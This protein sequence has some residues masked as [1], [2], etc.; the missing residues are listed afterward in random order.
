MHYL[1]TLNSAQRRAVEH[2][3]GPL[4]ILAGAGAG[5]TKTLTHRIFHLIKKGVRPSEILAITF[6]NKAAKEMRDRVLSLIS[7]DS[8]WDGEVPFVSTFHALGVYIL[9]NEHTHHTRTKYFSIMDQKDSLAV[10]KEATK[11]LGLD[12]KIHEPKKT[13]AIISSQ[14][15]KC[16]TVEMFARDAQSHLGN[17]VASIWTRY[18]EKIK[19]ENAY[20]FDDLLMQ[21]VFLFEQNKEVLDK[22]TNLWKY[23][24]IDEYQDTNETQYRIT[25]ALARHRN[26]CVVGDGDQ[27]IYTWRG[28]DVT[29]ILNFEQ[30]YPDVLVVVLEEN[31]RSTQKIL[32]A[33][34]AVISKNIRRKEKNLFTKNKEGENITIYEAS[35][36]RREAEYVQQTI[37]G[38][39]RHGVDTSH[40]AILYRANF[41]SRILEEMMLSGNIPYVVLGVRFFDRAEVKDILSYARSALNKDS[42]TD[43]K[44]II[45]TPK[46]G[47]GKVTI[48]KLFAGDKA[49]LPV[50]TLKKINDFYTLLDRIRIFSESHLPSETIRFILEESGI[51]KELEQSGTE[52]D[53][54]RVENMEELI[55]FALKYDYFGADGILK[56]IEDAALASDQDSL[57]DRGVKKKQE[58]V[59]LMTVHASKGLEFPHV[60]IV[61]LEQDLFPH[62]FEGKDTGDSD[63]EEERRLFYVAL[64]RAEQQVYLCY[65]L[66]RYIHG[67][68]HMQE[69]SE[70]LKDIPEDLVDRDFDILGS[71]SSYSDDSNGDEGGVME[72]LVID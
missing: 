47:I 7:E 33:A 39:L 60:F 15:N 10:L 4:L 52:E 45:N 1:E 48:A 63:D 57:D 28:A 44:R 55:T 64:T 27:T 40:I 20:D 72:Y 38:L 29:N 3:E 69:P 17:V 18:E 62:H 13:K 23:V 19:E 41:Q 36:D 56:M 53:L 49:S 5:K 24:H 67:E 9:R 65:A 14:K 26:I 8:F 25:K 37:K 46:R 31:Y 59:R 51:K 35:T 54:S 43:I 61:G 34:N 30:D 16:R 66:F 70:F 42:L 2:T 68:Q 12:P 50:N 22:Y 71:R 21:V 32:S 6:T 58:G 11:E